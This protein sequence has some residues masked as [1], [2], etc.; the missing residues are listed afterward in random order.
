MN[1]GVIPARFGSV[2]FPG[3]ALVRI[4]GKPLV[5]LVWE[6][7]RESRRLDR[8]LVATDDGRIEEAVRRFGGEAVITASDLPSGTDRVWEAVRQISAEIV[9][10]IQGDEPLVSAEMV[11]RLIRGLEEDPQAQMATLRFRVRG[12]EGAQ[13]PNVVKVVSD[14]RGRALYFSRSLIPARKGGRVGDHAWYKHLGIY[15]YRRD[16][17][18]RFVQ[19]PPS[20]LER[21]EE[22]EQLRALEHGV[23][24]RVLDSPHDTVGVDTPEDVKRVEEILKVMS[25]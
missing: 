10:N 23:R 22:L 12:A 16:L 19:W 9:V 13:D 7:V 5:Q 24:I 14:E 21:A 20:P 18:A 25:S 3:K 8:L 15:A 11:D 4:G 17:L 6:R 2:R 1:L